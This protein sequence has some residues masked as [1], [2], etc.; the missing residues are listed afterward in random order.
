MIKKHRKQTNNS[1]FKLLTLIS[2]QLCDLT[3][4]VG[5]SLP[6]FFNL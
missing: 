2:N 3:K 4:L 6:Q 1:G 5:T